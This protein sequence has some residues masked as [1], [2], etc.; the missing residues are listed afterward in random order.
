M[1]RV[2]LTVLLLNVLALPCLMAFNDIDPVT[3]EWNYSINLVGIVY[4]FG[5]YHLVLKKMDKL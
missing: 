4:S 3:G 5:Y 2:I 1:K